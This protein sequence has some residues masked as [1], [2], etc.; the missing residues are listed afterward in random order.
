MSGRK[1][2]RMASVR[3]EDANGLGMTIAPREGDFSGGDENDNNLTK[4]AVAD[5]GDF[6]CLVDGESM[7][8]SLSF[9]AHMKDEALTHA[10][11]ARLTDF[12][13]RQGS[14]ASA[15]SVDSGGVWAF[16]VIVT[17]TGVAT[18]KTYP[19]CSGAVAWSE[20]TPQNTL[21]CSFTNYQQPI[22][23]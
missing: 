15:V 1:T 8:Q 16:K 6:D 11:L 22:D 19:Y 4:V 9:T 21:G 17:W 14:F 12:I 10:T 18:S 23:A 5:R 13:K 20:G 2:P 3:L 7:Q